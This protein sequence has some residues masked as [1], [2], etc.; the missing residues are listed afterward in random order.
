M[1]ETTRTIERLRENCAI[2]REEDGYARTYYAPFDGGYVHGV[3]KNN[4]TSQPCEGMASRGPTLI[5]D[6]ALDKDLATFI[7]NEFQ[8]GGR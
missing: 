5:W 7:E 3:D 1:S 4:R 6:P 8:K 2:V